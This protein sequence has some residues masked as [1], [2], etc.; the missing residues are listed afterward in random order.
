MVGNIVGANIINI[1][2][3]L[4]LSAALRPLAIH[5]Q[6]LKLE[7]PVIVMAAVTLLAFAWDGVLSRLEGLVLVAMGA[8]FTLM[9]IRIARRESFQVK[10]EFAR[11]FSA[12]RLPDRQAVLE[13]L[14][15]LIGIVIIVAGADWLVDGA[16]ALARLW[17]V[18]AD[19]YSEVRSSQTASLRKI[20]MSYIG[21]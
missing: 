14:M 5:M 2:L 12:R 15:L 16:V 17:Q 7:L 11:E 9:I 10:R 13:L 4:G 21:G 6:T 8:A 20:E 19:R 1:L 18:R 3:V